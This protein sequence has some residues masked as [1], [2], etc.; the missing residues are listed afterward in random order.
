M[1]T[2]TEADGILPPAAPPPAEVPAWFPSWA[3][4]FADLYYAG[5]TC[6]FVLHGNVCALLATR[7]HVNV[8][9][10]DGALTDD[11][12]HII[13]HGHDNTSARQISLYDGDVINEPALTSIMFMAYGQT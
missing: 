13:T 1:A 7:D 2:P 3:H 8:F 5:T 9:L 6:L 4:D 11:P 12:E 10:Y